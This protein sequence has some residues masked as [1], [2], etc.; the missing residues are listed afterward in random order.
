MSLQTRARARA[1][2]FILL[3]KTLTEEIIL[4]KNIRAR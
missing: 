1:L 4:F 3:N 2:N